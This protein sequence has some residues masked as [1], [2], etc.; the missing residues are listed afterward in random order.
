MGYVSENAAY[1]HGEMSKSAII[2]MAQ[3][4]VGSNNINLLMPN[5]QFGTRILG[6]GSASSRYIHTELNKIVDYIYPP[7]DNPLL[8]YNDDDGI[9]VEPK[10]YVPIIPMVLVNGMNGIGTG[11]S[12]NIPK[13]NPVDVVNNIKNRIK[14]VGYSPM[15]PWYN[16]FI[17][18]IIEIE[19][20]KYISKGK[21]EITTPTSI[22]IQLPIDWVED[23]KKFLD[24]YFRIKKKS[25]NGYSKEKEKTIVDYIN[26]SSDKE[27][28]FTVVVPTGFVIVYSGVK[29][30]IQMELKNISN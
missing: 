9:L 2:G 13:F 4:Y 8:E 26:N 3:D 12:T 10:Y 29:N 16:N 6:G 7:L 22:R 14:G 18:E 5:G 15:K 19:N 25:E 17:G 27:I 1:H 23:Y 11:F 21:Y 20:N 28:N 24:S 30:H